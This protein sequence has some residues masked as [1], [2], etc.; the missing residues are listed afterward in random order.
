M[1]IL[2][3]SEIKIPPKSSVMEEH[4]TNVTGRARSSNETE[5]HEERNLPLDN[6]YLFAAHVI[7]CVL[8]VFIIV[9]NLL[10]IVM[11]LRVKRGRHRMLFFI[12]NLAIADLSV[13]LL[14]VLPD[15]LE[16]RA[17]DWPLDDIA[18]KLK[19]FFDNIVMFASTYVLV[20]MS[21]DRFYVIAWPIRSSTKGIRSAVIMIASVWIL[22]AIMASPMLKVSGMSIDVESRRKCALDIRDTLHLQ[23][24]VTAYFFLIVIIPGTAIALCYTGIVVIIWR[25]SVVK[26]HKN[27]KND[28]SEQSTTLKPASMKR[29]SGIISKAKFKS[30]MMTF[31][32][33]CTYIVCWFPFFTY[34]ILQ[35]YGVIDKNDISTVMHA[36]APLNSAANPLI[37]I[38]FNLRLFCPSCYVRKKTRREDAV[39]DNTAQED[40]L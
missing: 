11:V 14:F 33:V 18:C 28:H 1:E 27:Q 4:I 2:G 15:A 26:K 25:K 40:V 17:P 19:W 34:F 20:A 31:V 24:Y 9:L 22:S 3:V 16:D 10:V 23:I 21:F 29:S 12:V 32:I 7:R 37:C 36:T 39:S 30:M 8:C 13:G 38:V 35:V 5:S 6:P